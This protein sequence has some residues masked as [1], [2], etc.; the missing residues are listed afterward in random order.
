VDLHFT[1]ADTGIGIPADK[2]DKIFLAFEQGDNSTTRRFGGTGLGL[3][4]AS[5]LVGLMGGEITVESEPDQGST[6]RFRA[7]FGR[8]PHHASAE[9]P[10]VDLHGLRVLIVDDNATNRLILQQWLRGWQME[11]TAVADGLTA[12]NTLWRG[13]ALNRPYAVVLLDGRMPGV[14]GLA[15]AGEISQSPELAKSRIVLLTSEDHPGSLARHRE[16]GIAAVAMKPIQQGELLDTLYRILSR[17]PQEQHTEEPLTERDREEGTG[18]TQGC[19]RPLRILLAE[20]NDL[21][22][23]V[24]EHFL[25]RQGHKVQVARDGRETLAALENG[26]FDLLLLDVHMPELDGFRVIEAIRRREQASVGH[27]PVIALTARSMKGDRERCLQAGMDDYLAKPVRR[28]ELFAAIERVLAGK[29]PAEP[30]GLEAMPAPGVL[31]PAALLTACDGDPSLLAR[32]IAVFQAS[33]PT[34]L[35]KVSEAIDS[36]NAVELREAAHKLRGLVAAFSTTA[37][38]IACHLEQ[39]AAGGQLNGAAEEYA[40]LVDMIQQLGPLLVHLSVEDLQL[41]REKAGR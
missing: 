6:F 18:D 21:N 38:E 1:V 19:S 25:A 16:L 23:Q 36:R 39:T 40:T 20:D 26:A 32:M 3:S 31:D 11:P 13:V 2:Q 22:Q 27:L 35:N 34:H 33:V 7:C 17:S 8:Q 29:S 14:D 9:P 15:L 41:Q 12:L 28:G 37:A 10:L 24:V 5:R 4:I 30:L